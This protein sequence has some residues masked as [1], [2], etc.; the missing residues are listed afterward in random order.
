MFDNETT[1]AKF[2]KKVQESCGFEDSA[3]FM[4][5]IRA[6]P[7]SAVNEMAYRWAM[8]CARAWER[9]QTLEA[10][11]AAESAVNMGER[12]TG[13]LVRTSTPPARRDWGNPKR[14]NLAT[15]EEFKKSPE[16]PEWQ[17]SERMLAEKESAN[18][19]QY[20]AEMRKVFEDYGAQLRIEWTKE[21]LDSEFALPDGT[22]LTWGD[23]TIE[24]HEQRVVMF[25]NNAIAN[26]EG[27][28]RHQKAINDLREAGRA[29]LRE[30]A[31]V[32]A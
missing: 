31:G 3:G 18:W 10:E 4:D 20:H 8:Q 23:A 16:F 29:T 21:L 30:M 2:L 13:R 11:R 14:M 26:A 28:A 9:N 7:R 32:A 1:M 27:A 25:T 17:E 6:L 12:V 22:R 19:S 24:H 15:W 5:H